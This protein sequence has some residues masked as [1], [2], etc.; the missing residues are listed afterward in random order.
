MQVFY[1]SNA[2][3]NASLFGVDIKMQMQVCMN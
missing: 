2:S 1:D 3:A